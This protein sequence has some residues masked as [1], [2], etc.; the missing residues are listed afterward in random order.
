M[1]PSRHPSMKF[2]YSWQTLSLGCQECPDKTVCGGLRTSSGQF[3][4]TQYCERESDQGCNY[5]CTCNPEQFV[6][7]MHEVCGLELD[8]VPRVLPLV[9][10]RTP[11]VVP[12]IFHGSRREAP[13]EADVVAVKLSQVID[14][15][16]GSLKFFSREEMASHFKFSPEAKV[17][18]VGVDQDKSIEPYWSAAYRSNLIVDLKRLAPELVTVPNF[19]LFLNVPRWDNLYN[20]K[21]IALCWSELIAHGIP[22]SLHLNARTD[23]DWERW[24]EFIYDRDEVTSI[25]VEFATGLARTARGRWHVDKMIALALSSPRPLHLVVR[26]GGKYL[27]ELSEAFHYV[28]FIDSNAF[29]KTVNRRRLDSK[30]GQT[31]RWKLIQMEAAESLDT[32]FQKNLAGVTERHLSHI[33]RY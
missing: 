15:A 16:A 12:I 25:T 2:H 19:S 22:A 32:L 24:A 4:C 10:V 26:G 11:L 23:R 1:K 3:D 31:E 14:Y 9:P 30:P 28:T 20:M 29:M 13:L 21:R 8:N 17:I 27:R 7:R 5:V 18:F 33:V 6:S